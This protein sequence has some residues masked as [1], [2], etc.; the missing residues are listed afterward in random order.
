MIWLLSLQGAER[1]LP[2]GSNLEDSRAV[3]AHLLDLAALSEV[4]LVELL[5]AEVC[6]HDQAYLEW[7]G[8]KLEKADDAP[9][10]W[11][12]D[13]ES[14]LLSTRTASTSRSRVIPDELSSL[15]GET[16]G[17]K[18]RE[19]LRSYGELLLAWPELVSATRKL[20]ASGDLEITCEL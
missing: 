11:K 4:D 18:L 17:R 19:F 8:N 6:R 13:L 14:Y 9:A 7:L 5:R 20:K 16:S 1:K 12:A 3:G 10:F 15:F 2:R